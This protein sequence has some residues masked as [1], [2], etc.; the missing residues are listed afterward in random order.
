MPE[1]HQ[2]LT[3]PA[4]TAAEDLFRPPFRKRLEEFLPGFLGRARWF[5]GKARAIRSARFLFSLP[6]PGKTGRGRFGVVAVA[7]R[8]GGEE[9]YLLPLT[10]ALGRET[11][12]IRGRP[13]AI[14]AGVRIGNETGRIYDAASDPE[15]RE[16]CFQF[17]L[18]GGT[19]TEGEGEIRGIPGKVLRRADTAA[20][21]PKSRVLSQ[22]QSNTSF[23]YGDRFIL[24]IYR[25]PEEGVN[26]EIEITRFLTEE[27][28]FSRTP[29]FAG[30]L[31][32]SLPGRETAAAAIL[33]GYVPHRDDGWSY[34]LSAVS[35]FLDAPSP[36]ART[37][38]E[39]SYLIF[40]RR[41]GKRT[42]QLH[43]ALASAPGNPA[44]APEPES[45]ADRRN[46]RRAIATLLER[47]LTALEE[48][49]GE[50][51][52]PAAAAGREILAR[53]SDIGREIAGI[54]F[55]G[56]SGQKIRIHGD[57]HLG[58]ILRTGSDVTIIDFEGEPARTLKE[59]RR[60]RPPLADVAGMI[61]SFHY[62]ALGGIFLLPRQETDI[63]AS[64]FSRAD[65]WYRAAADAFLASYRE[66][67]A[68][69]TPL[70]PD[71]REEEGRLLALLLLEKAAYELN[72]ELN[73]RP[74]WAI[75][76]L[77]G[78]GELLGIKN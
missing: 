75:I 57:Y 63:P 30:T 35:R 78:L 65:G 20:K 28:A 36:E 58:Q 73:N 31:E 52:P 26:P 13:E 40:A 59:R 67:M 64:L 39:K 77:R 38:A 7:Y 24:K 22:E 27:A 2:F 42:A 47:G 17:I 48:T 8:D 6:L 74:D 53:R 32:L 76:P 43:R 19:L 15:F 3:L 51:S 72:Y 14:L 25:R 71:G 1:D 4:G 18:R 54:S 56:P 45:E 70:L 9:E 29:P 12:E 21:P 49:I 44:F 5:G 55:S 33:Q 69:G 10:L 34:T 11:E 66:T 37:K 68:A 61:R 46:R 23:L 16:G 60:K 62:A 41:L 50:L